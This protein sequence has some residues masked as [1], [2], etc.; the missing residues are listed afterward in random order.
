MSRHI[1]HAINCETPCPPRH[2][3]CA[4]HWRMVPRNLQL[5]VWAMYEP[6]QETTKTPTPEYLDAAIAA[7]NAVATKE[8]RP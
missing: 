4:R 1:C 6:G 2:L 7:I 5:D 3:M 8:G